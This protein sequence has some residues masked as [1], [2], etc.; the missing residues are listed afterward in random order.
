MITWTHLS[1][2]DDF[3]IST[4]ASFLQELGDLRTLAGPSLA[5]NNGD[6]AGFDL[7]QERLAMLG[8]GQESSWLV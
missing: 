7:V 8:N 4:P 2:T 6:W 1:D 3:A 5:H